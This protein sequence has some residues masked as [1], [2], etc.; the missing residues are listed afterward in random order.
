MLPVGS[1]VIAADHP[2]FDGHFPGF[3]VVPGV[4]LLDQAFAVIGVGATM[5]PGSVRLESVRFLAPVL[6]GQ[7]VDV[8]SK[9]AGGGR[10]GFVCR[11]EGTDVV[12]GE[13]R[14]AP[15]GVGFV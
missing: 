11:V 1:F 8:F 5:R 2:A 10:V 14:L 13:V 3:P 9:P 7:V 15:Q 4:V 12:V 6:P